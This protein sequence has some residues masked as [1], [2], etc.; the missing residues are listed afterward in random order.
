MQC[1]WHQREPGGLVTKKMGSSQV[2]ERAK[3]WILPKAT[4]K[5]RPRQ[6]LN[7]SPSRLMS[8]F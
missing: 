3:E 7:F 2:W 1:F 5:N 8:G 4:R 6:H